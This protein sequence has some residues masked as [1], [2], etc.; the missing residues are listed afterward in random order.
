[1]KITVAERGIV[2][3]RD[4]AGSRLGGFLR[5]GV[6]AEILY[7][8]TVGAQDIVRAIE[9]NERKIGKKGDVTRVR[10][11]TRMMSSGGFL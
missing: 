2:V 3:R 8:R 1:M 5:L 9:W 6:M 11:M 7:G 4:D 10:N